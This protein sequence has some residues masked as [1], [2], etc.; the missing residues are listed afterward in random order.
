MDVKGIIH[1]SPLRRHFSGGY[2][3]LSPALRGCFA[4]QSRGTQKLAGLLSPINSTPI[5]TKRWYALWRHGVHLGGPGRQRQKQPLAPRYQPLHSLRAH[6]QTQ[7]LAEHFYFVAAAIRV[8]DFHVGAHAL[9]T[10]Q[11]DIYHLAELHKAMFHLR[12]DKGNCSCRTHFAF[13][14]GAK[15]NFP[16]DNTNGLFSPMPM[17]ASSHPARARSP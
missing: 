12:W 11:L 10:D 9:L 4:R 15:T 3:E 17:E 16:T 2:N 5:N 13:S 14:P 6:A 1:C 7:F 8:E